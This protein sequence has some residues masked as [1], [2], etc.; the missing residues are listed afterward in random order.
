MG[1]FPV[2]TCHFQG[3]KPC[4][5]YKDICYPFTVGTGDFTGARWTF[6]PFMIMFYLTFEPFL[7]FTMPETQFKHI[8]KYLSLSIE[9]IVYKF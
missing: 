1:G 5:C 6:F 9:E 3:G 4:F 8:Y 2:S 7:G